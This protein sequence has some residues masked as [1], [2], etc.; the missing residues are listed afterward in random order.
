MPGFLL[1]ARVP[2]KHDTLATLLKIR[3]SQDET[4]DEVIQRLAKKSS[5]PVQPRIQRYSERNPSSSSKTYRVTLF[6]ETLIAA[7]LSDVLVRV[8]REFA[9]L[10]EA[11]LPRFSQEHGRTRR[12]VARDPKAIYPGRPDL[13]RFCR[14]ITPGWFV[15]TNYSKQDVERI[16]RAACE[17]VGITYG[18]DLSIN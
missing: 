14:Q 13:S 9:E 12:H 11:F 10:D 16:L 5:M 7:T 18:T 15:G 6:G 2:M 8:L 4:L 1:E 17:I 3:S